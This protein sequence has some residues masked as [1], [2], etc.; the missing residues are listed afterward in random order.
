MAYTWHDSISGWRDAAV[1]YAAEH[2]ELPSA[3]PLEPHGPPAPMPH[4]YD[5]A[6]NGLWDGRPKLVLAA[7]DV[8]APAP[9]PAYNYDREQGWRDYVGVDGGISMRPRGGW[10]FS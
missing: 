2:P 1:G 9:A 8:P 10:G 4:G 3:P 5:G 6:V 7:S